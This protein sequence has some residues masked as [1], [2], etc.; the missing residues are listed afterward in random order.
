[1]NAPEHLRVDRSTEGVVTV[2]FDSAGRKVNVFDPHLLRELTSV[3]A[4]LERAPAPALVLFRSGKPSGFLAG[5]DLHWIERLASVDEAEALLRS[6][7]ELF[8]RIEALPMPTVAVIHGP[9][10][11]GGLEFALACSLRVARDDEAT[12]LGLPET[13]LGLIPGWGGTQRLPRLI[14]LRAAIEMI[15]SGAPV[16]AREARRIGLVDELLDTDRL[17]DNLADHVRRW[18]QTPPAHS[19]AAR[20][21]HARND[22]S[23]TRVYQWLRDRWLL[24]RSLRRERRRRQ[25]N[26]ARL[27]ALRAL[28]AGW[29]GDITRGLAAERDEFCRVLFD[30][31]CREKLN[32]F[33][34]QKR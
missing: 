26:P 5:A 33:F 18:L 7:Q 29:R 1:M 10:L 6:G 11:G 8:D 28:A 16:T 17:E 24:W 20:G 12:R 2:T 34:Q 15:H 31:L 22:W 32:R 23:P 30:P 25:D 4:E 3:V 14:G 27:A 21:R 13:Q 19:P 9:C